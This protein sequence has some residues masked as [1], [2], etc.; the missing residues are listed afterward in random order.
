MRFLFVFFFILPFCTKA[1]N[2]IHSSEVKFEVGNL[3]VNTVEGSFDGVKGEVKFL[4]RRPEESYFEVYLEAATIE[5]GNDKRD[6]HLLTEDFFHVE[7]H[8]RISIDSEKIYRLD[9]NEYRLEGTLTIKGISEPFETIFLLSDE[10]ATSFTLASEFLV[11][12][13]KF[14]L[15]DS[16]GGFVIAD[17]IEVR[18]VMSLTK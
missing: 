14:K 6:E 18:V 1:Q 13:E 10:T 4:P 9:E 17:E 12:R 11:D 7:E 3:W 2:E 16:Y 5:T 8:P 15:G